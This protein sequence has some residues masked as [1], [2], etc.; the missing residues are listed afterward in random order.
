M[1]GVVLLCYTNHYLRNKHHFCFRVKGASTRVDSPIRFTSISATRRHHEWTIT[2]QTAR[3]FHN[4]QHI[5]CTNTF[6]KP[7]PQGFR[8]VYLYYLWKYNS[9]VEV[10]VNRSDA[11]CYRKSTDYWVTVVIALHFKLILFAAL[12]KNYPECNLTG[13]FSADFSALV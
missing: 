7:P 13:M 11:K 1:E 5:Q 2:H 9:K 10:T 6:N 3:C 8:F 12:M 4:W